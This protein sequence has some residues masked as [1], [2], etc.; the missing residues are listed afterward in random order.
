MDLIEQQ[1]LLES[2][3]KK[4]PTFAAILGFF[5]PWAAAFDNGKI[6]AGIGFLIIDLIFFALSIIGIELLLLLIYGFLG[7]HVNYKWAKEINQKHL[8]QL[9]AMRKQQAAG[10]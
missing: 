7:A 9:M 3:K 1:F 2:T 10:A 5:F 8:A 6:G 4:N